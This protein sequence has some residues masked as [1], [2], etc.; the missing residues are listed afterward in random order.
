[1]LVVR[2]IVIVV[3][4]VDKIIVVLGK[5]LGGAQVGARQFVLQGGG[6][7]V[8]LPGIVFEGSA[9]F[10]TQV[11]IGVAIA[12]HLDRIIHSDGAVVGGQYHFATLLRK[13][14]EQSGHGRM[15]VPGFGE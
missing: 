15:L 6:D 3:V 11:G 14:I 4:G 13:I 9:Q 8:Y 12:H 1:M 10:I 5:N 7:F 2:S